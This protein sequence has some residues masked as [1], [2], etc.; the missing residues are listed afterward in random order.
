MRLNLNDV[1]QTQEEKK[2]LTLDELIPSYGEN[3]STADDLKKIIEG[4]NKKI[5]ELMANANI[6]SH[7]VNGWIATVTSYG[8]STFNQAKLLSVIKK[9]SDLASK[10][11]KTQEYIDMDTLENLMYSGQVD[12]EL[13][14]D[15][16]KC[17]ETTTVTTLRIKRAK[18]KKGE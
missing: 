13:F 9:D 15:M 6:S 17:R 11:I 10:V 16:D 18:K 5:K 14:L 7:E 8:N 4:Q 3:K 2:E 12:K 1:A